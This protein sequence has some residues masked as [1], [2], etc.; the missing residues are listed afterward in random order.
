MIAHLSGKCLSKSEKFLI[1]DVQ[2]V[3]YR[4]SVPTNLLEKAENH[5][6]LK[7]HIHTVVREDDLS[8]YGFAKEEELRLFETL[9]SVNGVGPK[10]ALE[11]FTSPLEEIQAAILSENVYAL[12]QIPGIGKKT[13]ERIILELKEKIAP[14]A[15]DLA[16]EKANL[17][18]EV[19]EEAVHA[20]LGL[21]YKR[22]DI[23]RVFRSL[24]E[25]ITH[26]E[27]LIKYFLKN[28]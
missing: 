20:L 16:V 27:D 23:N 21:G 13:A 14:L 26:A 15:K 24:K 25:P 6:P 7:L 8:L 18:K 9:I 2:G 12:T 17:P 1:I 19:P 28:V 4:V 10:I 11:L 22:G 5:L 3:G